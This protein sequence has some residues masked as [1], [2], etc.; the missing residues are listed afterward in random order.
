MMR[1]SQHGFWLDSNAISFFT[2]ALLKKLTLNQTPVITLPA[3]RFSMS[4]I[5]SKIKN[6]TG[7]AIFPATLHG[8]FIP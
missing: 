5:L 3:K 6:Q 2:L 1:D 4:V 7:E 8:K